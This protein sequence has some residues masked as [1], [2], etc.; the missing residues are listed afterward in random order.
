ML[1]YIN[2]TIHL[3]FLAQFRFS[4]RLLTCSRMSNRNVVGMFL[5][6][7]FLLMNPNVKR[8]FPIRKQQR[9][10]VYSAYS[11]GSQILSLHNTRAYLDSPFL[12]VNQSLA[13]QVCFLLSFESVLLHFILCEFQICHVPFTFDSLSSS[14]VQAVSPHWLSFLYFL[15]L[16]T[17][18]EVVLE[19]FLLVVFVL[20]FLSLQ[21][22]KVAPYFPLLW[23]SHGQRRTHSVH[24]WQPVIHWRGRPFSVPPTGNSSNAPTPPCPQSRNYR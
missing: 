9:S 11:S 13:P 3:I 5:Y 1:I 10:V 22:T 24:T 14:K 6:T 8:V 21:I 16:K 17:V 23:Q 4:F 18:T 15:Q 2:T 7:T 20:W 12:Y 19:E